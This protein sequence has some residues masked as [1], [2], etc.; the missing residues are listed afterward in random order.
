MWIAY[1]DREVRPGLIQDAL[2]RLNPIRPLIAQDTY[3]RYGL[4]EAAFMKIHVA[5]PEVLE[6]FVRAGVKLNEPYSVGIRRYGYHRP[7]TLLSHLVE[8]VLDQEEDEDEE[9]MHRL[10]EMIP[11]FLR[12]G[13]D[14]ND[15][16]ETS[17]F[18]E[19]E[20]GEEDRFSLLEVFIRLRDR[21]LVQQL[22]RAGA[23][24]GRDEMKAAVGNSDRNMLKLLLEYGGPYSRE[25]FQFTARENPAF[26]PTLERLVELYEDMLR[27]REAA[28]ESVRRRALY[29]RTRL[30]S[31]NVAEIMRWAKF[32]KKM[33][34]KH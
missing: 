11:V 17:V 15:E 30:P 19:E 28:I 21:S 26:L 9:G 18:Q 12:N 25:L 8:S 10:H 7:V 13:A 24:V 33:R 23:V 1:I 4:L 34:R 16:V 6:A 2:A 5:G 32:G 14:P 27:A 3:L 22:L 29:S 20:E 31:E